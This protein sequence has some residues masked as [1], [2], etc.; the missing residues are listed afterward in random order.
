MRESKNRT[1]LGNALVTVLALVGGFLLARFAQ[2]RFGYGVGSDHRN[3]IQQTGGV[4]CGMT[5]VL[6]VEDGAWV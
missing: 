2:A 4:R 1:A 5:W 6:M 3:L